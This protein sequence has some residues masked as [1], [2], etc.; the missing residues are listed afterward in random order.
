MK[1]CD[2]SSLLEELPPIVGRAQIDKFLGGLVA[3]GTLQNLDAKGLGPRR[4]KCGKKSGYLRND[5]I[6]WLEA[7]SIVIESSEKVEG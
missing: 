6:A 7:R 5:L 3:K 4:I 2:L 1:K